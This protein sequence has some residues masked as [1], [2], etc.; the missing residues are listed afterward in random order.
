MHKKANQNNLIRTNQTVGSITIA[1]SL[2]PLKV[3][4]L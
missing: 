4:I 1:A 3:A 2:L